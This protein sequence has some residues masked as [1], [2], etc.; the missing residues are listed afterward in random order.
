MKKTIKKVFRHL[1]EALASD[2]A[3]EEIIYG[4]EIVGKIDEWMDSKGY[5]RQ[6]ESMQ[7]IALRLGVSRYELS[8]VSR[9]VY[10][11]NFLSLR[12]RLR[13]SEAARLLLEDTQAPI[14]LIGERVGITD[15]T[16]FRRQF[17]EVMGKTPQEWRD[18][19]LRR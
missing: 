16:N 8:W 2:P 6:D 15:R 11:D 10:G 14:S 12:K 9:K 3:R 18:I 5:C 1:K 19:H 4:R 17:V 13:I 7:D